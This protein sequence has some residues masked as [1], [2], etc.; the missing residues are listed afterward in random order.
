MLIADPSNNENDQ[1]HWMPC[2]MLVLW[3]QMVLYRVVK[4]IVALLLVEVI[5]IWLSFDKMVYTH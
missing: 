5:V 1:I 4:L 2:V 3:M